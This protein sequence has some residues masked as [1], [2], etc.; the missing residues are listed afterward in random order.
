MRPEE[1]YSE[2]IDKHILPFILPRREEQYLLREPEHP[3]YCAFYTA[4]SNTTDSDT[5]NPNTTDLDSEDSSSEGSGTAGTHTV[6]GILVIAHGFTETAD[7]YFEVI[8]YFLKAGYHVCIPEH[9]GHG[10]SYR[11]TENDLSLVHIDSWQRYADDLKYAALSAKAH[12]GQSLPLLLFA[13][14]TGG[15]VGAALAA[16]EPHLFHKIVLSSPMIRPCTGPVPWPAAQLIV[17]VMCAL[18]KE[19]NYVISQHP[20]DPNEP[21]EASCATSLARYAWY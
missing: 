6:K 18:G 21:F 19:Q 13:H 9:C 14:S 7:K 20:Y 8:Y 5:V 1:N 2:Y 12:W 11:L 3:I 10:R 4:D 16:Q 15:G 17:N